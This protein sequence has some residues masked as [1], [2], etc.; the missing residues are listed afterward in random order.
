MKY[1]IFWIFFFADVFSMSLSAASDLEEAVFWF[2][3]F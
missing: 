1:I 2:F 3:V